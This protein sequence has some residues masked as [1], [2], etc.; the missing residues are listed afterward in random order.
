MCVV[1]CGV[2]CLLTARATFPFLPLLLAMRHGNVVIR[3]CSGC[4]STHELEEYTKKSYFRCP[5]LD[6]KKIW[7][8][9]SSFPWCLYSVLLQVAC[10]ILFIKSA[11]SILCRYKMLPFWVFVL[12]KE[13]LHWRAM[14]GTRDM[15]QAASD[16]YPTLKQQE[17]GLCMVRDCF[18]NNSKGNP[19]ALTTWSISRRVL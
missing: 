7:N 16:G 10:V 14:R 19:S 3:G 13:M 8:L 2:V 15:N 6:H 4:G 17:P 11:I 5:D 18:W 9:S 12:L 1:C